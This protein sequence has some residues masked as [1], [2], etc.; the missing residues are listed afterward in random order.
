M[1]RGDRV[2]RTE[3][4]SSGLT[5][6]ISRRARTPENAP[7]RTSIRRSEPRGSLAALALASM[8]IGCSSTGVTPPPS[9]EPRVDAPALDVARG[10]LLYEAHCVLCHTTQA[11]WRDNSI[12]GSWNDVVVQVTRWQANAGQQWGPGEIGDVAAYLNTMYYKMPCTVPGCR[13]DANAA[14]EPD[15]GRDLPRSRQR[16]SAQLRAALEIPVRP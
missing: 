2:V 3:K 10:Q 5:Q 8:L 13:A 7:M 9:A 4:P 16:A 15:S 11:H 14:N 6:I 12:V 1:G